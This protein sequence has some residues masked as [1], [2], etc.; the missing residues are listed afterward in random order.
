[1]ARPGTQGGPAHR[2]GALGSAFVSVRGV[3]RDPGTDNMRWR[4]ESLERHVK[5]EAT[6]RAN[7]LYSE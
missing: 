1:M 3:F 7:E 4:A 5:S 2:E 6:S